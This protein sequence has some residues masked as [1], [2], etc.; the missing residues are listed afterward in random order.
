[1][2]EVGDFLRG[3]PLH[4][5]ATLAAYTQ[6]GKVLDPKRVLVA[7]TSNFGALPARPNDRVRQVTP[8]E[9]A[10]IENQIAAARQRRAAIAA[11]VPPSLPA[12][13]EPADKVPHVNF[14]WLDPRKPEEFK[15]DLK[16]AMKSVVPYLASCYTDHLIS[17]P[18]V[19][20]VT[21]QMTLTSDPDVGTLIDTGDVLSDDTVVLP[22]AFNTCIRDALEGLELPALVDGD[23]VHVTYPFWFKMS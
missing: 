22:L 20:K 17:A 3:S 10:Q 1:M 16:A 23:P 14:H 12:A 19:L 8:G 7:S 9:R 4:D 15:T 21:A 5:N 13:E 2:S 11:P 6:P 18:D